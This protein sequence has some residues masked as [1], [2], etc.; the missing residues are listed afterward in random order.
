MMYDMRTNRRV[1]FAVWRV[2]RSS[3]RPVVTCDVTCVETNGIC[4]VVD[5]VY[6]NQP[7]RMA[8]ASFSIRKHGA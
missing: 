8:H 1:R 3:M 6:A 5:G 4:E 7:A 2:L